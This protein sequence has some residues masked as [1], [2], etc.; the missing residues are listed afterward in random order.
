MGLATTPVGAATS[1]SNQSTVRVPPE[2]IRSV[3]VS[4][5]TQ[6]TFTCPNG[7][8]PRGACYVGTRTGTGISGGITVTNGAAPST[9]EVTGHPAVPDSRHGK[10][11][12]LTDR[13][14]TGPDQFVELTE[15]A[16]PVATQLATSSRCD[17][18]FDA[19]KAAC[20]ATPGESR[21]ESLQ[22]IGPSTSTTTGLFTITT[23][24]T[25]LPPD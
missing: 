2:P 21:Q 8:V 7:I 16:G 24:W 13:S 9:I 20:L 3:T 4:P 25:A 12:S 1:G 11:W 22:I 10:P 17:N 14:T 15:S 23:T 18:S 19:G 5:V 6:T